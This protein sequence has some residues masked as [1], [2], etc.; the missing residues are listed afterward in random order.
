M[1][2][3]TGSGTFGN[4]AVPPRAAHSVRLDRSL[5]SKPRGWPAPRAAARAHE[6]DTE[7][8]LDFRLFQ[9]H[10]EI[11][12]FDA[13]L[14]EWLAS[15]R[16]RFATWVAER[17]R[18]AGQDRPPR[19]VRK[20]NR[21]PN[22]VDLQEDQITAPHALVWKDLCRFLSMP[23]LVLTHFEQ[24]SDERQAALLRHEEQRRGLRDR[25][26]GL[27]EEIERWLDVY[28]KALSGLTAGVTADDVD[29]KVAELRSQAERLDTQIARLDVWTE[30]R[31]VRTTRRKNLEELLR[32][33]ARLHSASES[34]RIAIVHEL[35]LKIEIEAH[36]DANGE[37]TFHYERRH[38]PDG[39]F[40]YAHRV[41]HVTVT[42]VYQFPDGEIPVK[43]EAEERTHGQTC[44]RTLDQSYALHELETHSGLCS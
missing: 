28:P 1:T 33:R 11:A 44:A 9:F 23:D 14:A 16:G 43:K 39:R 8:L 25:R 3:A 34:E 17:D 15:A 6:C 42:V 19:G 38:R 22:R 41:P 18:R 24:Q 5:R 7:R 4:G 32:D 10:E 29:R 12:A 2:L 36:R 35:V 27:G 13:Q 30:R 37:P 26:A 21:V 20:L 31:E 40:W